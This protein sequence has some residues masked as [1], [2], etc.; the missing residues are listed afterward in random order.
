[1]LRVGE[2]KK[3]HRHVVKYLMQYMEFNISKKE[4][5]ESKNIH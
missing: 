2:R 1:M 3:I 5:F 4:Y